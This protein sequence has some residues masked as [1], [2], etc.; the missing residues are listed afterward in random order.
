MMD[1]RLFA[2]QDTLILRINGAFTKG[3]TNKVL[4]L[5]ERRIILNGSDLPFDLP[6]VSSIDSAGLGFIFLVAHELRQTRGHTYVIN[7]QP[8]VRE[9][10]EKAG[11]PSMV[12]LSPTRIKGTPRGP[13]RESLP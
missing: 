13:K 3:V 8:Q 4:R 6:H 10:L 12:H 1:F 9:S 2:D 11:L 7:P 5:F